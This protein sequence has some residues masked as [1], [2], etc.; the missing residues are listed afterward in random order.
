MDIA[1]SETFKNF[2][3]LNEALLFIIKL[4][5][6]AVQSVTHFAARIATPMENNRSTA[7]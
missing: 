6:T 2:I 1:K 4:S 7:K 3:I 5:K